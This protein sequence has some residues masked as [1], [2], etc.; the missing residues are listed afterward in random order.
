MYSAQFKYNFSF[1]F[2][3]WRQFWTLNF[4]GRML[5]HNIRAKFLTLFQDFTLIGL[6]WYHVSVWGYQPLCGRF[7]V[8][9]KLKI[10]HEQCGSMSI[11]L[12]IW[13]YSQTV[14]RLVCVPKNRASILWA[15]VN[16]W[17]LCVCCLHINSYWSCLRKS[18]VT[19]AFLKSNKSNKSLTIAKKFNG[20]NKFLINCLKK[21][22]IGAMREM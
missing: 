21:C 5:K 7:L 22:S 4:C 14:G 13:F 18:S 11:K 20:K 2:Q 16:Q 10:V 6:S 19:E 12:C 8:I 17:P 3:K 1:C 9:Y 15:S